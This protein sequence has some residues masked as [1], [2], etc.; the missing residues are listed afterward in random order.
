MEGLLF[1]RHV[2]CTTH[3]DFITQ[4]KLVS[5]GILISMELDKISFHI[6][7]LGIIF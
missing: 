7:N 2:L 3:G 1:P 5:Q 4:P 6:L